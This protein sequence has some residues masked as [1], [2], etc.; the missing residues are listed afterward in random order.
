MQLWKE[1]L[2]VK[3]KKNANKHNICI[4]LWNVEKNICNKQISTDL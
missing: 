1:V 4:F 3:K 2:F